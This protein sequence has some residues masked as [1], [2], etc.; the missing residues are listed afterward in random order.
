[1]RSVFRA[2]TCSL[3]I[4][5]GAPAAAEPRWP[6]IEPAYPPIMDWTGFYIGLN[7]GFGSAHAMASGPIGG[8]NVSASQ[9]LTGAIGGGQIG[10]NWQTGPV[11][12]GIEADAQFANQR[13]DE[14]LCPASICGT[15]VTLKDEV[16]SFATLR[17]RAGF[18]VE[19]FLIYATGGLAY[20]ELHST[21]SAAV[22]GATVDLGGWSDT[23]AAW[24]AGG[25]VEFQVDR[26]WSTKF[27]YLYMDTGNFQA[28]V[29]ALGVTLNPTLRVSDQIIRAGLNYRF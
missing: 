24:T 27:E 14:V 2:I 18:V 17:G 22:G 12:L 23:R 26:H 15:D 7:G 4:V 13:K 11:V 10:F 20:V 28:S 29:S 19:R 5:S 21:L 6:S 1:M 9:D 8:V 25:G 3:V 16:K